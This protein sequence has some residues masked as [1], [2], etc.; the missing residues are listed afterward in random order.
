MSEVLGTCGQNEAAALPA[1]QYSL[2]QMWSVVWTQKRLTTR[3][4]GQAAP[5]DLTLYA[6]CHVCVWSHRVTLWLPTPA[7]PARLWTICISGGGGVRRQQ[8][9]GMETV[10]SQQLHPTSSTPSPVGYTHTHTRTHARTHVRT[11][12]PTH[13]P[14]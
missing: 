5:A 10:L 3:N 12:P 7:L 14:N 13:P 4:M 9:W 2:V 8:T 6:L 1:W 11:H